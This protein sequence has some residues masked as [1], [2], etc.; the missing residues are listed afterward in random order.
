MGKLHLNIIE[1]VPRTPID[2]KKNSVIMILFAMDG[3][4]YNLFI[5][6]IMFYQTLITSV[7]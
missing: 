5:Y 3:V 6:F 2:H 4:H 7:L 1:T